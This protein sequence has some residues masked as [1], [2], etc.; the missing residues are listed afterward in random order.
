MKANCKEIWICNDRCVCGHYESVS[1][2]R[3]GN[4]VF[5]PVRIGGDNPGPSVEI[6]LK[7]KHQ[8]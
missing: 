4:D 2:C 8:D 5:Y 6:R 3:I 7:R 1:L